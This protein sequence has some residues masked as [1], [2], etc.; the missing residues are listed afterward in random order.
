MNDPLKALE[1]VDKLLDGWNVNSADRIARYA[2]IKVIIADLEKYAVEKG[3]PGYGHEKLG[4][5]IWHVDAMFG[6]DI[7]NGHDFDQHAVWAMAA[8]DGLQ[9][10]HGFAAPPKSS[11]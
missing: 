6:A 3:I 10:E 2:A 11:N 8:V 9:S 7:D 5:L 1:Q 4:T